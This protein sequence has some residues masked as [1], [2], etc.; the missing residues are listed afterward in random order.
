MSFEWCWFWKEPMVDSSTLW[1]VCSD[2]LHS[3]ED[4]RSIRLSKRWELEFLFRTDTIDPFHL[5]SS[6]EKSWMR[7]TGGCYAMKCAFF[8]E[9]GIS[10]RVWSLV[11]GQYSKEIVTLC[12]HTL[13]LLCSLYAKFQIL[14][15][16]TSL[17]SNVNHNFFFNFVV[18]SS[19]FCWL[20]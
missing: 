10:R 1:L 18:L 16:S 12:D 17:P 11:R 2:R 14:F 13:T 9:R 4:N 8:G 15:S 6:S 5:T 7:H 3:P 19:V 20:N